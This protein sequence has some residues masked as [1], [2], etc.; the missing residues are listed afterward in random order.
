M[1]TILFMAGE[2]NFTDHGA[3]RLGASALMQ[4]VAEEIVKVQLKNIMQKLGAAHR[5]QAILPAVSFHL[6]AL[7]PASTQGLVELD[8][9]QKFLEA[10]LGQVQL[11]LEQVTIGVQGVELRVHAAS[12]AQ[13]G[14]A[15]AVPQG[16]R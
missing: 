5:T 2:T 9:G 3:N 7:L 16:V 15:H 10:N 14:Q 11:R 8:H 13:V 4:G 6:R 12:I 1:S